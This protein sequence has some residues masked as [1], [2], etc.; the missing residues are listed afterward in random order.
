[1][2]PSFFEMLENFIA[3]VRRNFQMPT[4]DSNFAGN[5][6]A[7][8]GGG[9][10]VGG[11][12]GTLPGAAVGA[13][14]GGVGGAI[15]SVTG[16]FP[17][18]PMPPGR[19]PTPSQNN[20]AKIHEA[21]VRKGQPS[22]QDK[23]NEM[24]EAQRQQRMVDMFGPGNYI[25]PSRGGPKPAPPLPIRPPGEGAG[26]GSNPTPA[27]QIPV[28]Q[29]SNPRDFYVPPRQDGKSKAPNLPTPSR[30]ST[31]VKPSMSDQ[32][33]TRYERDVQDGKVKAPSPA[34]SPPPVMKPAPTPKPATKKVRAV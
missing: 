13:V 17:I 12:T 8:A 30:P 20:I 32:F 34:M 2:D 26:R 29:P 31:P 6:L 15:N 22:L 11:L 21:N 33:L 25:L 4:M 24:I 9:A 1:M 3:T 10:M 7:G 27:P 18:N 5:V 23:R 14:L 28:P 16:T 19:Y